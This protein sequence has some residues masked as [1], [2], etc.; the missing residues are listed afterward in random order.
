MIR[1]QNLAAH[2]PYFET[3]FLGKF[4][5]SKKS[6]IKKAFNR[7]NQKDW[8]W[9]EKGN[10]CEHGNMEKLWIMQLLMLKSMF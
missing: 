10:Y 3:L 9:M 7:G 2:S 4:D 1:F 6:E 5:E 8:R